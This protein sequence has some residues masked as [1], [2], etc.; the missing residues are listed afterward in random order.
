M[1]AQAVKKARMF[2]RPLIVSKLTHDERLVSGN[3][4]F[5]AINK[6]GWALTANHMIAEY[7]ACRAGKQSLAD[8]I[9]ARTEIQNSKALLN[10]QK[11]KKLKKL[12]DPPQNS[13]L[14]FAFW[15]G[16]DGAT[17][18][19]A[20]AVEAADLALCKLENFDFSQITNYPVFKN[21]EDGIDPGTS[22]CRLGFPWAEVKQTYDNGS[23]K[24]DPS[25]CTL[26]PNEGI[27]T[28][29]IVK[30]TNPLVA[31]IET[32][33]PGLKG[34]SGGPIFDKNGTVWAI[35][36]VTGHLALGFSP[37]VPGKPGEV[38]HQFMNVGRGAHPAT[39][40]QLMRDKGVDFQISTY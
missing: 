33:S 7:A 19:E 37:E 3:G 11:R 14:D 36:S 4:S 39:I 13:I 29:T 23:F 6:D 9:A 28:R 22:L 18:K 12:S 38:E 1:F 35:Q 26:F 40:V 25:G 24:I 20:Y 17:L 5:V 34:Q 8:H 2:T 10:E 31:L 15:W 21:P 30:L 27:F 16:D 32:S